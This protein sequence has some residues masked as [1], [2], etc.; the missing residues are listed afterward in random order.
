[1]TWNRLARSPRPGGRCPARCR[2]R[3]RRRP[4]SGT[5]SRPR[6][7]GRRGSAPGGRRASGS[8]RPRPWLRVRGAP[9][10]GRVLVGHEEQADVLAVDAAGV[11]R[12]ASVDPGL[13]GVRLAGAVLHEHEPAVAEAARDLRVPDGHHE[14]HRSVA[15]LRLRWRRA[16]AQDS[17]V[18]LD[19]VDALRFGPAMSAPSTRNRPRSPTA[20]RARPAPRDRRTAARR[21]RRRSRAGRQR[22]VG[23]GDPDGVDLEVGEAAEVEVADAEHLVQRARRRPR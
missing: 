22:H 21:R 8:R 14:R 3:A 12:V 6:A 13:R 16:E 7:R 5:R 11:R 15:G 20:G 4:A 9:Q 18:D 2:P 10:R 19:R 1:M 17:R 23:R